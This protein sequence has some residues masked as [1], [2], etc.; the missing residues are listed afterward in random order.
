MDGMKMNSKN[1][2]NNSRTF[3]IDIKFLM[4]CKYLFILLCPSFAFILSVFISCSRDI[5]SKIV[6]CYN[7]NDTIFLMSDFFPEEWDTLYFLSGDPSPS[8]V[9]RR[10]GP[11]FIYLTVDTGDKMLLLT[12]EKKVVY[13]KEWDMA[14]DQKIE[15]SFFLYRGPEKIISISRDQ[16]IFLIKKRDE[17]SYCVHWIGKK[18]E[19]ESVTE[20]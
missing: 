3:Q 19:S 15:G 13:Y 8:E 2:T 16:A 18:E 5:D 9:V 20:N 14:Y 17:N 7:S 1:M 11:G 6:N 4:Q 10:L 12:R